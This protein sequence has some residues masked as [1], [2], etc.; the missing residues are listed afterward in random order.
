MYSNERFGR[1]SVK[2]DSMPMRPHLKFQKRRYLNN[3]IKQA[4]NDRFGEGVD[5]KARRGRAAEASCYISCMC[6][7]IMGPLHAS[8]CLGSTGMHSASIQKPTWVILDQER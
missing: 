3:L 1:D 8:S 4:Q 5:H 7:L 2:Q 6:L